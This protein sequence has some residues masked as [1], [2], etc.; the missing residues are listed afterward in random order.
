[1]RKASSARG[2]RSGRLPRSLLLLTLV[3]VAAIAGVVLMRVRTQ[4]RVSVQSQQK[5][6]EAEAGPKVFVAP[7][8]LTPPARDVTLPGEVRPFFLSTLYAK[9]PGYLKDIRVDKGDVVKAGEL[10]ATIESPETDREIPGARTDLAVKR[11]LHRR[12]RQMLPDGFVSPQEVENAQGSMNLAQST[13]D[14]WRALQQYETVTAPFDGL[15]TGRYV[16]PGA[17]IPAAR[18]ATESSMPIV[19]IA[20]VDRVR[21]AV[22]VGQDVSGIVGSGTPVTIVQDSPP[23]FSVDSAV[24][25]TAGTVDP[26]SRMMLCEIWLD[27]RKHEL[28]P[29]TFVRVTLHL[30]APRVTTIPSNSLL[31]RNNVQLAAVVQGRKVH[32][33]KIRPGINDGVHLEV[34]DGLQAGEAVA[35]S[36][37]ADL[38]DGAAIQ[39]V[40][41]PQSPSAEP[42][43]TQ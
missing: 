34:L 16:D 4:H 43:G 41:Q 20:Q 29:G 28:Q 32:F 19:D 36:L 22:Y 24:T 27:N 40:P 18:S 10:L 9:I 12:L 13:F 15:I 11:R 37:P 30:Q 6:Q 42:S 8:Q 25:R 38:E 1:M 3:V 39:P 33:A 31:V 21:I 2:A 23:R 14:S 35:V 5:Q 17:L 7:V 26:R